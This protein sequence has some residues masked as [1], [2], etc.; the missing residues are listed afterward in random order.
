M[1]ELSQQTRRLAED[2]T[3]Q[4]GRDTNTAAGVHTNPHAQAN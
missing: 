4:N 2:V 3:L 1:N